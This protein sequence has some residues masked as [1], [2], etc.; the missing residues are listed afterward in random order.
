MTI[1]VLIVDDERPARRKIRAQLD[2]R[3]DVTIVGE[4]SNGLEAVNAIRELSPQLVF[5]DIQMPGLNGFEVIEAI[6]SENMPA[7]VFVTAY[8]EHALDAFEVAAVDYL[9]KPFSEQR[10]GSALERALRRIEGQSTDHQRMTDLLANLRPATSHLRRIVVKEADRVFFVAVEDVARFV[11]KGNYVEIHT[12]SG[13]HLIRETMRQIEGRLDPERFVRIHRSEII[14]I[15]Y[16]DE[17]QPW[18]HGD[19]VV[20][21]KD[22]SKTKMSRRFSGRLL[23]NLGGSGN[24]S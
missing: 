16:I 21:L 3:P 1:R 15:D 9:L 20:I 13:C 17:L 6:G 8:D 24:E 12:K 14:N 18:F 2:L 23:K 11:A 10:F 7:V 5:L 4:A 19:Y 22:G